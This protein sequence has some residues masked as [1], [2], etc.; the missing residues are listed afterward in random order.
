[1]HV[2]PWL[3][4]CAITLV[5]W[6]VVGLLQKPP[7]VSRLSSRRPYLWPQARLCPFRK[8]QAH[9]SKTLPKHGGRVHIGR[10]GHAGRHR[11]TSMRIRS[12]SHDRIRSGLYR[13]ADSEMV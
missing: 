7:A 12:I 8:I 1:M 11:R 2:Q 4:Y 3:W 5:A 6:G 13:E 10:Q 9:Y